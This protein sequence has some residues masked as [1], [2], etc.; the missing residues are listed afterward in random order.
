MTD[1][2]STQGGDSSKSVSS[3]PDSDRWLGNEGCIV[4]RQRRVTPFNEWSAR[5]LFLTDPPHLMWSDGR[6]IPVEDIIADHDWDPLI[7]VGYFNRIF[8]AL[9]LLLESFSSFKLS[10]V[11]RTL[12]WPSTE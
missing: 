11:T 5:S 1:R 2:R 3:S 7:E 4:E 10:S 8:L 12:V 9:V 6:S